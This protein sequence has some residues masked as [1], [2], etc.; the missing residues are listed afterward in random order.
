MGTVSPSKFLSLKYLRDLRG[1]HYTGKNGK[2]YVVDEVESLIAEKEN[3]L[4]EPTAPTCT[5]DQLSN[6][7][8]HRVATSLYYEGFCPL[9]IFTMDDLGDMFTEMKLRLGHY[10]RPVDEKV[11]YTLVGDAGIW[12]VDCAPVDLP[13]AMK[14]RRLMFHTTIDEVFIKNMTGYIVCTERIAA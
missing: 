10:D 5:I 7:D 12:S 9:G 11:H 1:N 13:I 3:K 14:S 8:L 2:E 6:E 4:P